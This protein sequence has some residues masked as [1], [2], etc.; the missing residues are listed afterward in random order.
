[1][2]FPPFGLTSKGLGR[3]GGGAGPPSPQVM[4]PLTQE[5]PP[6]RGGRK[7]GC[8]ASG[9]SSFSSS[10]SSS[11]RSRPG[12]RSSYGT[13]GTTIRAAR[14]GAEVPRLFYLWHNKHNKFFKLLT[15]RRASRRPGDRLPVP[16]WH[17][18]HPGWAKPGSGG[19]KTRAG[20][21]PI[22][23]LMA[24]LAPQVFQAP[25]GDLAHSS[26]WGFRVECES[27]PVV[28]RACVS[29]GTSGTIAWPGPLGRHHT[30]PTG[31]S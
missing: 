21:V 30:P 19:R 12:H 24:Q 11:P 22:V 14:R 17:P 23:P 9:T 7:T 6:E 16:V 3:T 13:T 20:V 8:G 5:A 10:W 25:A 29:C 15:S 2:H 31:F 18:K 1:M 26:S 27:A 28:Q 4:A